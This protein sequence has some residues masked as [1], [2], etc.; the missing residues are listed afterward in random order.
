LDVEIG[1]AVQQEADEDGV[2]GVS[3]VRIVMGVTS[4]APVLVLT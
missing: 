2:V 1:R 3:E 4:K